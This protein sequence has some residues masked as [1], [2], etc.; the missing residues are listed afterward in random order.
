MT[1][2]TE[3]DRLSISAEVQRT[4]ECPSAPSKAQLKAVIDAL[5]DW[6]EAT[7]A[8]LANAAIPQ[9]QR[10]AMTVR[11]KAF[12]FHRVLDKKYKGL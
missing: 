7:G 4:P 2:L 9:P 12:L 3:P 5:D 10:G 6:W 11:Q 1:A 8:A